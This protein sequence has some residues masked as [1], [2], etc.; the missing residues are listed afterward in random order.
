M[1]SYLG[2]MRSSGFMFSWDALGM[3]QTVMLQ[4]VTVHLKNTQSCDIFL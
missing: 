1:K 4:S 2:K 3:L